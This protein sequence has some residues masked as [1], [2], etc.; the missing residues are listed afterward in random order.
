MINTRTIPARL[1]GHARNIS[2]KEPP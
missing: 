1:A 2:A